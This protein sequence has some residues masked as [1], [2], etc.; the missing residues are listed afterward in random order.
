[1]GQACNLNNPAKEALFS[2][3]AVEKLHLS[4]LSS[5]GCRLVDIMYLA[6]SVTHSTDAACPGLIPF[7]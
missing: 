3:F 6:H 4:Y 5:K 2:N 1:M 7:L